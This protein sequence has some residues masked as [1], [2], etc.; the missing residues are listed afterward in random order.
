MIPIWSNWKQ[1]PRYSEAGFEKT[2]DDVWL[3]QLISNLEP[4]SQEI[5]LLRFGQKSHHQGNST[6]YGTSS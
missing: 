1:E 4:E 2:E 5:L 6:D 3:Q